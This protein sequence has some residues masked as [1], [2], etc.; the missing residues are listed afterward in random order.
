MTVFN[1][2]SVVVNDSDMQHNNSELI[3]LTRYPS[4][5]YSVICYYQ[6]QVKMRYYYQIFYNQIMLL[7]MILKHRSDISNILEDVLN[8]GKILFTS[9]QEKTIFDSFPVM[10]EGGPCFLVEMTMYFFFSSIFQLNTYVFF[11]T[12]IPTYIYI[13]F[14]KCTPILPL[15]Y[16]MCPILPLDF[17]QLSSGCS[18]PHGH[19]HYNRKLR[20]SQE[21]VLHYT[22]NSYTT[23][24]TKHL[25][26]LINSDQTVLSTEFD[27]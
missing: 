26:I 5:R 3:T 10:L 23:F 4:S 18:E 17:L 27:D 15:I 1:I 9:I 13:S 7:D 12:T 21:G 20:L 8:Q 11:S 24:Q 25:P 19:G 16:N 22:I 6:F 14:N 2:L